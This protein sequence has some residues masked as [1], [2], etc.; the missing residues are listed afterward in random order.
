MISQPH[1]ATPALLQTP[2]THTLA[3]QVENHL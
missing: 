1:T 2:H 3:I